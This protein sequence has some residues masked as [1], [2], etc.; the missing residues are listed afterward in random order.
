M[1]FRV[2]EFSRGTAV[3]ATHIGH[4][5]KPP[6]GAQVAQVKGD[7]VP[8]QQFHIFPVHK[9]RFAAA[10]RQ[11]IIGVHQGEAVPLG[12]PVPALDAETVVA[13]PDSGAVVLCLADRR[14]A[15]L[16][17]QQFTEII[18]VRMAALLDGYGRP[19]AGRDCD[20]G[21]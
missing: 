18:F 7:R 13:Y 11:S 20:D 19:L 4:G 15:R 14:V 9:R 3:A 12:Q 8:R 16:A 6:V 1:V 17:A 21:K 5:Q 2:E 10:Q